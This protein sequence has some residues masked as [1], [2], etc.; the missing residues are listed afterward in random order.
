VPVEQVETPFAVPG[1]GFAQDPQCIGSVCKSTHDPPQAVSP[2]AH[3]AAH[4]PFEQTRSL[5]HALRH[6]PQW[7]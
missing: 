1:Y 3:D 6:P 4:V 7:S 2:S 5:E